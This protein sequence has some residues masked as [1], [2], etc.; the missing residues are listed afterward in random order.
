MYVVSPI[1]LA[2]EYH[3]Q[4]PLLL[5]LQCVDIQTVHVYLQHKLS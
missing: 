2:L 1:V 4:S 3:T 5:Q